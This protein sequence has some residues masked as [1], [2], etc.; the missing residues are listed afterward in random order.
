MCNEENL[1]KKR[2]KFENSTNEK[3]VCNDFLHK[4]KSSVQRVKKNEKKL[5][6]SPK[7]STQKAFF[8]NPKK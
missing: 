1:H 4:E 2:R 6:F 8:I 7:K 5:C 3:K